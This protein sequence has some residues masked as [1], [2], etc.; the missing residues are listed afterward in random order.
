MHKTKEQLYEYIKDLKTQEEFEHELQVRYREYDGLL[1][2]PTIALLVVDELGRNKQTISKIADLKSDMKS[3]VFGEIINFYES[4]HFTRKN[5]SP[6]RVINLELAD[7]TGMCRL[8]LWNKDVELVRNK[9]VQKGTRVKVV[10][11]YVKNGFNGLELNV[12]RWSLL[13]I[14]PEDMPMV[15]KEK[16]ANGMVIKGTLV[17]REPTRVFFKETGEVGF[18][19]TIKI[20]GEKSLVRSLTV[21]DEKVKELQGFKVGDII[22]IER[23][24]RR[25]SQENTELHVNGRSTIKRG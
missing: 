25:N 15:A 22:E 8:V 19:T 20:S 2:E 10:N 16:L 18:V 7:E 5:G 13:E 6:G 4:R 14:E 24:N 23:V 12:G 17:N 3:T 1:D 9:T 11:G 21:W